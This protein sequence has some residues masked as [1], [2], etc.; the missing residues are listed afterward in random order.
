MGND[1]LGPEGEEDHKDLTLHAKE[2]FVRFLLFLFDEKSQDLSNLGNSCG[3]HTSSATVQNHLNLTSK[4]ATLCR[5]MQKS[6]VQDLMFGLKERQ[7][8][9]S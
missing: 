9:R 7:Q 6:G 4:Q 5:S 3:E 1:Y 2:A 8:R